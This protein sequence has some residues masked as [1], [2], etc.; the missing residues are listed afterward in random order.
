MTTTEHPFALDQLK[1]I[2][3]YTDC[4]GKAH[5]SIPDNVIDR[6]TA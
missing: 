5:W 6:D 3:F 4:L 1:Q 2:S